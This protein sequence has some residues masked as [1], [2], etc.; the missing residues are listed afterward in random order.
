MCSL[1]LCVLSD[2]STNV[3]L[4]PLVAARGWRWAL[5]GDSGWLG[6]P[7]MP[8]HFWGLWLVWTFGY[9]LLVVEHGCD[10][11]VLVGVSAAVFV[12]NWILY[13][14]LFIYIWKIGYLYFG[15]T[16]R[17]FTGLCEFVL[18]RF[19]IWARVRPKV[20]P[21]SEVVFRLGRHKFSTFNRVLPR[22]FK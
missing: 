3:E 11:W 15:L 14:L 1:W 6:G 21:G 5:A 4:P 19:W 20:T 18:I 17:I 16:K 7:F 12:G 8:V 22:F 10:R 9:L 13:K 2:L